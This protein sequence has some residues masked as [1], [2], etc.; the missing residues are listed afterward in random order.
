[1]DVKYA[2]TEIPYVVIDNFMNDQKCI[3]NM[4]L[5]ILANIDPSMDTNVKARMTSYYIPPSMELHRLVQRV[6]KAAMQLGRL[7]C[8]G[9]DVNMKVY[10]LWGMEYRKGH[11][12][13]SHQHFPSAVSFVY[14]PKA[15]PH[16]PPLVFSHSNTEIQSKTD[17]MIMFASFMVHEVPEQQVD[18]PRIAI[19]GN[20]ASKPPDSNQVKFWWPV[21]EEKNV[22]LSK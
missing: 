4:I 17:R 5:H 10:N 8:F 20:L 21:N 11:R 9:E 12:A 6:E 22:F 14:Y 7:H 3:D 1:M 16:H 15:E 18:D 13:L 2:A 19:S